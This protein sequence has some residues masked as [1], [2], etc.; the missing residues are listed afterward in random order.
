MLI[1]PES[2]RD[3]IR[4]KHQMVVPGLGVFIAPKTGVQA[5]GRYT[6]SSH[7]TTRR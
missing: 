4:P 5:A 3:I 7:P 1:V 6:E 2:D